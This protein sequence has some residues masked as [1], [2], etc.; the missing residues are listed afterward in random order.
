MC[1]EFK[2]V[3]LDSTHIMLIFSREEEFSLLI[4]NECQIPRKIKCS[5]SR[6]LGRR[7]SSET[8]ANVCSKKG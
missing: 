5:E 7:E 6:I 2:K 1:L 3:D 4:M 8:K